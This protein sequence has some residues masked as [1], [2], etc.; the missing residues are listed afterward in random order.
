MGGIQHR[1]RDTEVDL[2]RDRWIAVI[3]VV[4]IAPGPPRDSP[5][6]E[7]WITFGARST[8]DGSHSGI[9]EPVVSDAPGTRLVYPR[10]TASVIF[11]VE[12]VDRRGRPTNWELVW[13]GPMTHA[14]RI[15]FSPTAWSVGVDL[16]P[17]QGEGICTEGYL[18]DTVGAR[19]ALGRVGHR[20]TATQL[21]RRLT[22]QRSPIEAVRILH[23]WVRKIVAGAPAESV[24]VARRLQAGLEP[25]G[26]ER[27]RRR[28]IRLATGLSAK[29]LEKVTRFR[30]AIDLYQVRPELSLA[31]LAVVAGYYDQPHMNRDFRAL[32]G[33]APMA[34]LSGKP[35][36]T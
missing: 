1:P 9:A 2:R 20:G 12:S 19:L 32:A 31:E 21:E 4:S 17:G 35:R 11:Q 34:L 6:L 28:R 36:K 7:A 25:A 26:S 23:E 22:E 14:Y 24:L 5:R 29:M 33:V 15:P 10:P 16:L 27:T 3:K 18:V 30:R 8:A 13:M